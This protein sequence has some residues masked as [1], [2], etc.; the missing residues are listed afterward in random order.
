MQNLGM[1]ILMYVLAYIVVTWIGIIHTIINIK[2]FHMKSIQTEFVTSSR[3]C[4]KKLKNARS[5]HRPSMKKTIEGRLLLFY[6]QTFFTH[7]KQG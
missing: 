4:G 7:S 2:V 5:Y 3:M 6:L 1:F